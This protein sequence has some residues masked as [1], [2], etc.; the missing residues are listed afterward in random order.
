[1]FDYSKIDWKKN[2]DKTVLDLFACAFNLTEYSNI[3][4]FHIISFSCNGVD[5][6]CATDDIFNGPFT[7]KLDKPLHLTGLRDIK[8]DEEDATIAMNGEE[9]HIIDSDFVYFLGDFK[10]TKEQAYGNLM[11]YLAEYIKI[12]YT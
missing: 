9:Y 2:G 8:Y 5:L 6:N 7:V 4:T 10:A 11:K 3:F 12:E 1:M